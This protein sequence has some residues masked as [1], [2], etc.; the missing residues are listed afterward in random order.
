MKFDKLN[1]GLFLLRLTIGVLLLFHGIFKMSNG[2]D[3][4]K[5]LLAEK[6]IPEFIAY[7]VYL[8]EVVAPI[9][10]ILGFRT[11][12]AAMLVIINMLFAIFLVHSARILTLNDSGAWAIELEL[13]F[14]FGAIILSLTGG[15]KYT[16][17][18]NKKWD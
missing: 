8:G 1:A 15:G 10:L 16:I 7:G 5:G 6:S 18:K 3:W 2:I 17:S 14:L 13:L 11:R 9:F 12:I 4:I